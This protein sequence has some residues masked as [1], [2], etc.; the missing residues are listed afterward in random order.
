MK[1]K[2]EPTILA[3]LNY[4]AKHNKKSSDAKSVEEYNEFL[5]PLSEKRRQILDIL[6]IL[7]EEL[8]V[9]QYDYKIGYNYEVLVVNGIETNCLFNSISCI[10]LT[11]LNSLIE[12]R[13]D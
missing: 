8:G 11:F 3:Y 1:N 6:K 12:V 5:K 13:Y 7:S 9:T 2:M 4:C 10:I